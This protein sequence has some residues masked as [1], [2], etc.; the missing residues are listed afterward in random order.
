[1]RMF[2]LQ[3]EEE[4]DGIRNR[5]A[6]LGKIKAFYENV[7]STRGGINQ[8]NYKLLYRMSK[9]TT[10]WGLGEEGRLGERRDEQGSLSRKFGALYFATVY[11]FQYLLFL[12]Y[13]FAIF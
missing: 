7:D 8:L 13:S 9:T 4:C 10:C 2:C 11:V 6:W 3:L 5:R 12:S 1:M